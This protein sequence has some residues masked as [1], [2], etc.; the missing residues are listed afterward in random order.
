MIGY[1]Y[2]ITNK[3]N[4]KFY[5][6]S[7]LDFS[8]RKKKHL[9][10]LR[11]NK[12]HNIFLQRAYNLYGEDK[13]IFT[14]KEIKIENR[15]ELQNIEERYI[16]FC[17]NSKK[18][19]NVSK[20]G[21]GGDL[22]SYHPN[23]KEIRQKLSIAAKRYY[24]NMT[25]EKKEFFSK[26]K[27]G[28][29]N[30]NYRHKWDDDKKKKASERMKKKSENGELYNAQ[31]KGRT[32]EEI[33]GEEKAKMLKEKLSEFASSRKGEKNS[34]YGKHHTDETKE[35]ISKQRRGKVPKNAKKVFYGGIIYDSANEC[36]K[37]I[38]INYLTVCY[39]A[40]NNIYGF[41]Y[42]DEN[43][44]G[45]QINAAI[46]WTEELSEEVAKTC[47]TKKEFQQKYPAAYQ[48]ACR[49]GLLE[50]FAEKYFIE[51]R[52]RWTLSEIIEKAKMYNS[53][54]DFRIN[55][56]KAYSTL[57]NHEKAWRDEVKKMFLNEMDENQ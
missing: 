48:Y 51:L 13:F 40:R 34:F 55:E 11:L 37:K 42:I 29:K 50:E 38:G 1:I 20:K 23:N 5:I 16:N 14:C 56:T 36:A 25:D 9:K 22:V 39:R 3:S 8:K 32:Y 10:E 44:E 28:D 6:G 33:Y 54:N 30:P 26:M 17:W 47:S 4:G 12:H 2:K 35:K 57:G 24:A 45:K 7:T 27:R 52:H 31:I 43:P 41:Y 53:F 19:Y 21:C 15:L 49:N 46:R 18:L